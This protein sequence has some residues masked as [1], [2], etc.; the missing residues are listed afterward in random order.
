MKQDSTNFPGQ[1]IL[2]CR[3]AFD[4]WR[5]MYRQFMIIYLPAFFRILLILAK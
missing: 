3:V 2:K 1:K 5:S 4:E